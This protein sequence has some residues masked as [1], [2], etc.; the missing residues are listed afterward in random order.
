[1][2]GR[3]AGRAGC[4]GRFGACCAYTAHSIP[5][6]CYATLFVLL[7]GGVATVAVFLG[8]FAIAFVNGQA[9]QLISREIYGGSLGMAVVLALVAVYGLLGPYICRGQKDDHLKCVPAQNVR[10]PPRLNPPA[11][12]RAGTSTSRTPSASSSASSL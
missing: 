11:S 5:H 1:M 9:G 8:M 2:A 4:C 12:P 3:V 7:N 10:S 6:G